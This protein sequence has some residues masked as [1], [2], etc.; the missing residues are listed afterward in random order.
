MSTSLRAGSPP[1]PTGIPAP[2][3]PAD[4]VKALLQH[5]RELCARAVDPLEIAAVLEA[6]G[7]ADH[8]AAECRHRDLFSL[9]EELY[10]RGRGTEPVPDVPGGTAT[11]P[12][13]G[14]LRGAGFPHGGS[15]PG[16]LLRGGFLR[17][18]LLLEDTPDGGVP[19]GGPPYGELPH[20]GP[21]HR[22][23]P[24]GGDP[25]PPC[26]P[27]GT[28]RWRAARWVAVFWLIGY[29]LVGDRLLAALLAGRPVRELAGPGGP[30]GVLAAAVPTALALACAAAP[31]A[32]SARW[33]TARAGR[34][35][36]GSRTLAEFRARVRPVPVLAT[37]FHLAALAALLAAGHAALRGTVSPG[38]LAAV[39]ALGGLLFVARLAA[40]RGLGRAAASAA[41][42]A[43]AA[44][45]AALLGAPLSPGG[46]PLRPVTA[47]AEAHGPAAV[48]L[49]ACAV[50]ALALLTLALP[51]LTR[52]SA[53]RS[54]VAPAVSAD[55][56][57]PAAP[58]EPRPGEPST[59]PHTP[60]RGARKMTVHPIR[61][62]GPEG[63]RDR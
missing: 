33:F 44:E 26:R 4:P 11:A 17:G 16:S 53:H 43:C 61:T 51:A 32:W 19:R 7:A 56:A 34:A 49:V 63:G 47:L 18:G 45:A 30:A 25:S 42:A 2:T 6:R 27:A 14:G 28:Y 59:G 31:A 55:P 62:A 57:D 8:T 52:A 12:R 22:E 10:A 5:H 39:T 20:R 13:G 23:P 38:P 41:L 9:A 60:V 1:N 21:R 3:A 50:P 29:G 37:V 54:A 46:G 24:R 15:P 58:G 40:S 35:L 36:L 48:P